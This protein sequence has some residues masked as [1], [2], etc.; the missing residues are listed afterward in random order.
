MPQAAG[1]PSI[2]FGRAGQPLGAGYPLDPGQGFPTGPQLPPAPF[3][4]ALELQLHYVPLNSITFQGTL[5]FVE[6]VL[7]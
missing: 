7:I 6:H 4:P 1:G 5:H 3:D 2:H